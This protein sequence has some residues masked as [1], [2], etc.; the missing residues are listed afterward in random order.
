MVRDPIGE[1][2]D[3]RSVCFF[4]EL[5]EGF[6]GLVEGK[7]VGLKV[8]EQLDVKLEII[9]LL[10]IVLVIEEGDREKHCQH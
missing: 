2:V 3:D 10:V 5:D 7:R 8:G 6:V 9:G 1:D 4:S